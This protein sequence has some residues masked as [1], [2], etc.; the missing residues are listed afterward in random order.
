MTII[1]GAASGRRRPGHQ[2]LDHHPSQLK[3]KTLASPQL[4]NTQDVALRYW[5]KTPGI[6]HDT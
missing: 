4:A 1:S 6:H 3:G 2:G 5:L